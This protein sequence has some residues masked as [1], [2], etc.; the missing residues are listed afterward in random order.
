[1][2]KLWIAISAALVITV[3]YAYAPL[4]VSNASL[5]FTG[6][7]ATK[8]QLGEML[9]FE[10]LL[11]ADKTL[12]CA[13][14]HIPAFGFADTIAF[15]NGV[16]GHNGKRNA[17]SC[18]NLGDRPYLFYDGRAATLED[19]VKFPIEDT[20]EMGLPIATAV[21]RLQK[22]TM[23]STYFRKIFGAAPTEKNLKAAIAAFERT[24]ETSRTPFDRYMDDDS[25]AIS[26]SAQRGRDLFMGS[27][28]KCFDCHFSPDFT[29]DEFRNIGLYD[30]K[31]L[32]DAGRYTITKK[33]SDLGKFKTPG[34][35]NV[36]VTAP[37]MHNGIFRTLRE[38]IEYYNDPYKVVPNPINIDTLLAKP[39]HLTAQEKEDLVH[40]LETLTD[41]RFVRH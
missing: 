1:M 5:S 16:H 14:C 12:S 32:N 29:G 6:A 11:S 27:K 28:A 34:L 39:L 7:P 19:Q 22:N 10:K 36:A 23:Y 9:F 15:S 18:A 2:R 8:Q 26:A 3:C 24:L 25:S 30:G 41:D 17:P 38:V 35:R 31:R 4:Q 13:S 37:Y 40:F 20:N 21:A 33:K